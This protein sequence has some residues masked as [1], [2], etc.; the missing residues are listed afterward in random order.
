[1]LWVSVNHPSTYLFTTFECPLGASNLGPVLAMLIPLLGTPPF[2]AQCFQ[3]SAQMLLLQLA[4]PGHGTLNCSPK[5]SC[6]APLS[7]QLSCYMIIIW[8]FPHTGPR[9]RRAGTVSG[10]L[11][12]ASPTKE[13]PAHACWQKLLLNRINQR[14]S[15]E[16]TGN[17]VWAFLGVTRL[18]GHYQHLGSGGQ[19]HRPLVMHRTAHHHKLSCTTFPYPAKPP[20]RKKTLFITCFIYNETFPGF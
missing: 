8:I 9:L 20:C 4:F 14:F 5:L 10:S 2:S 7:G 3:G 18:K 1:M 19:R 13:C 17:L 6:T 16:H 11:T 12:Y 15:K